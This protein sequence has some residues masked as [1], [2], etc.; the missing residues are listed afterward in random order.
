M[1]Q[2]NQEKWQYS[3]FEGSRMPCFAG[4]VLKKNAKPAGWAIP[5][6]RRIR[7]SGSRGLV[8]IGNELAAWNGIIRWWEGYYDVIGVFLSGTHDV[9]WQ[10]MLAEFHTHWDSP[11]A[12]LWLWNL[13]SNYSQ[14]CCEQEII[15]V[16]FCFFLPWRFSVSE[17]DCS[18]T[19]SHWI[20]IHLAEE[21]PHQGAF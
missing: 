7:V 17:V 1:T 2:R 14:H 16:R 13:W 9:S 19:C 8:F 15:C 3:A 21:E 20:F 12:I 4:S 18:H 11:W 6:R 5:N 10:M